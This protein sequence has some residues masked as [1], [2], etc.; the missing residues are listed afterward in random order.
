MGGR[1]QI[2]IISLGVMGQRMLA[3]LAEHPRARALL[4][5]DPNPATVAEAKKRHPDLSIAA[6]PAE[7][8]GAPALDGLYIAS[9]PASH[10]AYAHQGF[11]AGL[12]VFC[13]KPLTVD[14]AEGRRAIARIEAGRLRSGVNFS[15]ASSPGLA[16]MTAAISDGSIGEPERVDIELAFDQ[17][18]RTWQ[19]AAGRWLAERAEGGFS[20]EVLSH[21]VFVLQRALGQATVE[22]AKPDYPADGVASERALQARLK[23]GG[24]PVTVD[25]RVGGS[26]PDFNRMT[27]VGSAGAIEIHDWFGLR[28]RRKDGDWIAVGTPQSNRQIGQAA[29]LDQVME[30]IEGRSHTLPSFAE[31]LAVQETIEAILK[32]R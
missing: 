32:G 29:Q 28:R 1:K 18:P 27:L 8:I 24:V 2:G 25:A 6:T 10:L 3:R 9:P 20:R 17:W 31:A 23:A 22:Q 4:A 7:V 16:A 19:A 14:F 12:A 15:L 5:W 26:L 21:F 13:E 30:M 11:D